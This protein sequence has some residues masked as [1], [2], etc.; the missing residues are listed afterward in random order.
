[1]KSTYNVDISY[2]HSG[3]NVYKISTLYC[4]LI[5]TRS[6]LDLAESMVISLDTSCLDVLD[7]TSLL[8]KQF[9]SLWTL[10]RL[11]MRVSFKVFSVVPLLF[12]FFASP[13]ESADVYGILSFSLMIHFVLHHPE[14][15]LVELK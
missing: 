2:T 14:V 9:P 11:R 3:Q 8:R 4:R 13:W 12:E 5:F 7:K 6:L 1:M 15:L 10:K